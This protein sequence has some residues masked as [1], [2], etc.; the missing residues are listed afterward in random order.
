VTRLIAFLRMVTVTHGAYERERR[1][2]LVV[3]P[4]R[5][6]SHLP[7]RLEAAGDRDVDDVLRL[8]DVTGRRRHREPAE[9]GRPDVAD[10]SR[11]VVGRHPGGLHDPSGTARQRCDGEHRHD[12]DE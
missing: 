3:E 12:D 5:R 6:G 11:L 9:V 2:P 4:H 10:C 7:R 8:E 1:H